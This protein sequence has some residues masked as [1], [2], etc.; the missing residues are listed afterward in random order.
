MNAARDNGQTALHGAALWGWTAFVQF[1]ADSG[2]NLQANDRDGM[3]PLDVALGKVGG[4]GRFGL[5][6]PEP[7]PETA[8]LLQ[9]LMAENN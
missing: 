3:T 6:A 5:S 9:K 7:H 8:A 1:L 2:A 4:T